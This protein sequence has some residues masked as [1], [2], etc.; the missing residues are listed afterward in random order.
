MSL[1]KYFAGHKDVENYKK[2]CSERERA[3]LEFR[4]KEAMIRNLEENNRAQLE[5]E[6]QERNFE[7]ETLARLDVQEYVKTCKNQRR[8]S[9]A[10]RAKEKRWHSKWNRREEERRLQEQSRD[11]RLKARDSRSMELARQKEKILLATE[12]L[13]HADCTFS[14]PF[15]GLYDR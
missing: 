8:K 4:R 1:N 6:E 10:L 3:S 9:L 14:N 13:R 15:A 11:S 2:E 7:L 5:R 12:A